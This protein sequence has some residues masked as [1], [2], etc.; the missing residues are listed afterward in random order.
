MSMFRPINLNL[1]DVV[2]LVGKEKSEE[3]FYEEKC[4]I[5]VKREQ[6]MVCNLTK[7]DREV[8]EDIPPNTVL[9]LE[10]I[11]MGTFAIQLS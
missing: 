4:Q 5:A 1:E 7:S 9:R 6:L 10:N 11:D 8:L 3:F 2:K